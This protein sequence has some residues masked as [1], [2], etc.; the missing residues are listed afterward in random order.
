MRSSRRNRLAAIAVFALIATVV[1]GGITWATAATLQLAKKRVLEEHD[2]RVSRAVWRMDSYM[3]GIVTAEYMRKYTDYQAMHAQEAV[4]VRSSDHVELDAHWVVLPSPLALDGPPHEWIDIYFQVDTEGTVSS[5]QV[6]DDVGMFPPET[7]GLVA[8]ADPRARQ[9]LAWFSPLVPAMDLSG[10]AGQSNQSIDSTRQI[11]ERS[12]ADVVKVVRH[13]TGSDDRDVQQRLRSLRN[14]QAGSLPPVECVAPHIAERNLQGRATTIITAG[15]D[16]SSDAPSVEIKL[17]KFATPFW[18]EPEPSDGPKLA[19]VRQCTADTMVFYQ[20]FVGDWGRLRA[21]LLAQIQDVA[22]DGDIDLQP[23]S[24]GTLTEPMFETMINLPV[25]LSVPDIAGGAGA[26]A[27]RGVRGFLMATWASA[28]IV[29]LVAGWGLRNLVALTE[30]RMQFAYAVTHELRTPLTTFRLYA[31]MLST[32][33]V[34]E[35][36]KSQYLDTLNRESLRLSNLVEGVLEYSRL[37]NHHVR[38]NPIDTDAP[39]LLATIS[40]TLNKHCDENT[41]EPRTENA[42]ANGQRLRTDVDVLNR[43]A[44]VLVNNACRHARGSDH[45]AVL[46]RLGSDNGETH[47][48]VIDTGPGIDRRDARTI[49]KPFRRGRKADAS[50]QGGIGLGLALARS[51]ATLLGGRLEL[52]SNHHPSYGGAHFRLTFPSQVRT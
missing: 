14:S 7:A 42:I 3:G 40:E 45:A 31:D 41:I 49:F 8:G 13:G 12:T 37:E 48:D 4:V 27:W 46:V 44:G 1:V 30:R 38:L 24:A 23:I 51:W 5:P 21:T 32:G 43:I 26:A 18:I 2:R 10:R 33:M 29:L 47:L 17:G 9:T 35:E 19:F 52:V 36:S 50:A 16:V 39:S 6:V 22:F 15:D 34:P 28:A 25:R 20:G 11:T